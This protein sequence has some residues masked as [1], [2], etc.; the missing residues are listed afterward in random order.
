MHV[1][2]SIGLKTG[3]RITQDNVRGGTIVQTKKSVMNTLTSDH[4]NT[5]IRTRKKF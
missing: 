3:R 4:T 1:S 5:T 2:V